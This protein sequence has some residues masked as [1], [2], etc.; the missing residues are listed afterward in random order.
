MVFD[1]HIQVV[2]MQPTI[3]I[4]STKRILNKGKRKG[5]CV[6]IWTVGC[7]FGWPRCTHRVPRQPYPIYT[8]EFLQFLTLH[9]T[10]KPFYHSLSSLILVV[11]IISF[12]ISFFVTQNK[13]RTII[14]PKV[15]F[16]LRS[17]FSVFFFLRKN[18]KCINNKRKVQLYYHQYN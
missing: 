5:K 6:L 13:T 12:Y 3:R 2:Q 1:A 9:L 4:K 18:K 17:G 15:L 8:K 11:I 14:T 7:I 16:S 10:P